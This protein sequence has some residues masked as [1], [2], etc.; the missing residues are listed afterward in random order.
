LLETK[1][2]VLKHSTFRRVIKDFPEFNKFLTGEVIQVS[3]GIANV[4]QGQRIDVLEE[5]IK[6]N[7]G[8]I[9][10]AYIQLKKEEQFDKTLFGKI[11]RCF[12]FKRDRC[13]RNYLLSTLKNVL[14]LMSLEWHET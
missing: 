1:E 13:D 3:V 11:F 4:I 14:N 12:V 7:L 5:K 6:G 2:H 9:I 8:D 10:E